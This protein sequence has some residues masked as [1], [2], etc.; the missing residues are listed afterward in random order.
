MRALTV[1]N[2]VT[3]DGR[4]EDDDH[5]IVSFFEHQHTDYAGADSFDQYTTGLLQASD[6]LLL[7]G[8]RSAL[9]NL[10]YW[11]GVRTDPGATDIRRRFAELILG[12]EK[13][14]VSDTITDQDVAPYENVRIV[15]VGDA[16][17]EVA[18]L[19]EGE[20]RGIL[21]L[22][23]RVLWNDLMHAGLVDELHLVTFPLIAGSGVPLFDSR[24]PVALKLLET[25]VWESSGN[26]LMRWRVDPD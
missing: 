17:A 3:V 12:V 1:C 7:S 15:R 21:I 16:R 23:G 13:L 11:T 24:P 4:Y 8:R 20:G 14:V 25:R 19:K 6:T 2:F 10:E 26:V 5:D 18:R 22:L 9:G